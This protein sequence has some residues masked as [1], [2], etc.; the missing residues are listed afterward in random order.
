MLRHAF[1]SLGAIRVQLKTDSRNLQSQRAMQKL[2]AKKEG[3]LRK[4]IILAD[5][6]IRDTVMFSITDDEWPQVRASLEARLG[7]KP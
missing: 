1:D 4:H 6:H 7:Y 5:G 3:T 2:G